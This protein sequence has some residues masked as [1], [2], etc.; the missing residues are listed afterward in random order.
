MVDAITI[1]ITIAVVVEIAVTSSLIKGNIRRSRCRRDRLNCSSSRRRSRHGI[2][3]NIAPV[4]VAV[5][6]F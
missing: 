6:L 5:D 1:A 2:N 4:A 3:I